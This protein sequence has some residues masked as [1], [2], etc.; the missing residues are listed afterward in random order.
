MEELNASFLDLMDSTSHP[1]HPEEPAVPHAFYNDP[2]QTVWNGHELYEDAEGEDEDADGEGEDEEGHEEGAD[3][4][5]L[6]TETWNAP[7]RGPGADGVEDI[8]DDVGM[9]LDQAT[10]DAG[11]NKEGAD[12][13]WEEDE[14]AMREIAD[15]QGFDDD[16]DNLNRGKKRK[17]RKVCLPSHYRSLGIDAYWSYREQVRKR[18]TDLDDK[19]VAKLGEGNIAYINKDYTKAIA[20]FHEVIQSAPNS[21]Q[22]WA[23]LA[24]VHDE[25]GNGV[26]AMGAYMMAAHLAPK[27]TD[28]WSR[29]GPMSRKFGHTEQALYCFT[30]AIKTDPANLDALCDRAAIY[31]ERKEF[32]KAINDLKAILGIMPH[33][34]QTVRELA[35]IYSELKD[36]DKATALFEGALR[37]DAMDPISQARYDD[38]YPSDEDEEIVTDLALGVASIAKTR[39]NFED[40]NMLAELYLDDHRYEQA[41]RSIKE[42]ALR[43]LGRTDTGDYEDDREFIGDMAEGSELPIELQVKL[44][45]SRLMLEQHD[46]ALAHFRILYEK[47]IQHYA[48]LYFEVAEAYMAKRMIPRAIAILERLRENEE[49]ETEVTWRKMGF[50]YHQLGDLDMAAEYYEEVLVEKPN[51][52]ETKLALAQIYQEQGEHDRA[53]ILL[54]EVDNASRDMDDEEEATSDEDPLESEKGAPFIKE[55]VPRPI[56]DQAVREAAENAK[57]RDTLAAYLKAKSLYLKIQDRV[58]RADFLRTTRKL[59]TR[60]ENT[61]AFYPKD[62]RKVYTGLRKRKTAATEAESL[63]LGRRLG[64]LETMPRTDV[65]PAGV[66]EYQGLSFEEWYDMFIKYAYVA[67][68][69]GKEDEAQAA[70]KAAV[71]ANVFYHD[72]EKRVKL[73]LHMVC[74]AIYAGNAPRV[75]E[76]CRWFCAYQPLKNDVYRLYGALQT[77]GSEVVSA[78]TMNSSLKYFKR[79]VKYMEEAAKDNPAALNVMLLTLYGHLLQSGRSY[80][81]AIAFY[82]KAY[83]VAPT[84]PMINLSLGIAHIHRSMQR[85]SDNRH[86]HIIQGVT[87][88]MRYYELRGATS[89]ASYNV[90]RAF[91][92]TGL[93]HLAIPYYEEVLSTSDEHRIPEGGQDMKREAAYNL[94]LIYVAIGSM[95]LA[96]LLLRKYCTI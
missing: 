53:K 82:V 43:I 41:L 46:T 33:H 32:A 28:L 57:R 91:H 93:T 78:Y 52:V 12:I 37:A 21:E 50:C 29:L 66:V 64:E 84:D 27:G 96:E 89:E 60:F 11:I 34:M 80:F 74:V 68:R 75:T 55:R 3:A 7:V 77:G 4:L 61:R 70:L 10:A 76:L 88:L 20:I 38:E 2:A 45:I 71:D 48:D 81:G 8:P 25:L 30:C 86:M 23:T 69:D 59:L 39:V 51:D 56:R 31:L 79:Q 90:A 19:Q 65:V 5:Q 6:L 9:Q 49:T 22:A 16:W 95:G 35:K 54:A 92:Q 36:V 18:R 42:G 44:G 62:R 87:C 83:A 47:P 72:E 63:E 58:S 73:R 94:S 85:K 26:K 17:K 24:M 13:L 15:M 40:L 14:A 67:V 1:Q